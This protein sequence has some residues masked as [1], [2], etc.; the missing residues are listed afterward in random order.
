MP[1][2]GTVIVDRQAVDLLTSWVRD[3]A[4]DIAARCGS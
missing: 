1:P 4:A 2:I 3:D